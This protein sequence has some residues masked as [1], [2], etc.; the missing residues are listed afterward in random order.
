LSW[1][2]A[3]KAAL[4]EFNEWRASLAIKEAMK[5]IERRK[6]VLQFV[7]KNAHELDLLEQATSTLLTI[8]KHREQPTCPSNEIS[9]DLHDVRGLH[10]QIVNDDEKLKSC[11]TP[12]IHP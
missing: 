5:A 9:E 11:G 7:A 10:E 3:Y 12:H 8:R 6:Q 4:L 2:E 1:L